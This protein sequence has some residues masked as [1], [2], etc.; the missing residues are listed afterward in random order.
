V[1]KTH[2]GSVW[3]I[4]SFASGQ[5]GPFKTAPKFVE[6]AVCIIPVYGHIIAGNMIW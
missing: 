2:A 3:R 1:T 5:S 6:E 4:M